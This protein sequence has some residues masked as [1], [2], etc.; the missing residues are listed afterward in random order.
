ME[1]RNY[2]EARTDPESLRLFTGYAATLIHFYGSS[3][4]EMP[5]PHRDLGP[6]LQKHGFGEIKKIGEG[7]ERQKTCETRGLPIRT[8]MDVYILG[9]MV[10][11]IHAYSQLPN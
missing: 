9:L 11:L 4:H 1:T 7:A 5:V 10:P 8:Y 3:C 2:A 6:I